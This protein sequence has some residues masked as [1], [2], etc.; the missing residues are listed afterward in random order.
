MVNK[1]SQKTFLTILIKK[2]GQLQRKMGM[3]CFWVCAPVVAGGSTLSLLTLRTP[4]RTQ[5]ASNYMTDAMLKWLTG[6]N[7][8]SSIVKRLY[9]F[10]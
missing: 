1:A 8:I 5:H 7:H 4:M 6:S 10:F 2:K 3:I 9:V